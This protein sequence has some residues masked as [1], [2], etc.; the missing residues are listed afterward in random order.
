MIQNHALIIDIIITSTIRF[1]LPPGTNRLLLGTNL[2]VQLNLVIKQQIKQWYNWIWAKLLL[3]N[4]VWRIILLNII[5]SICLILPKSLTCSFYCCHPQVSLDW[6]TTLMRA[7]V[8]HLTLKF[9][10]TIMTVL[11]HTAMQISS[12]CLGTTLRIELNGLKMNQLFGKGENEFLIYTIFM[13]ND[14]SKRHPM[15]VEIPHRVMCGWNKNWVTYQYTSK[16]WSNCRQICLYRPNVHIWKL[17][18][19]WNTFSQ[20]ILPHTSK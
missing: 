13:L 14:Q 15:K 18:D 10:V 11:L 4:I 19:H 7:C 17:F 2:V 16:C 20:I 9:Y 3:C 5:L 6:T 12:I 1:R 8:T